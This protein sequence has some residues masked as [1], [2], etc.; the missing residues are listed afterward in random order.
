M[1]YLW[2]LISL[3]FGLISYYT[4][5]TIPTIQYDSNN[6]IIPPANHYTGN[7]ADCPYFN[8]AT[9]TMNTDTAQQNQ[10]LIQQ[11]ND[12]DNDEDM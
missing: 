2:L 8:P 10:L 7:I 3:I 6:N 9:N 1:S 12:E 5:S 4:Y 11:D